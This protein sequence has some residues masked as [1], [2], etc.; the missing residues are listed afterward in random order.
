MTYRQL[1]I[2]YRK[3]YNMRFMGVQ[4]LHPF[5]SEKYGR[6]EKYLVAHAN[7]KKESFVP[8]ERVISDEELLDVHTDAFLQS[9]RKSATVARIAELSLLAFL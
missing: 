9:L 5:D 3:E 6:I 7:L 2:L 8:P 1:P 4:K